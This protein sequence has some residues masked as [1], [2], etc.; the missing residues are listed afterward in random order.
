MDIQNLEL[1][2][3]EAIVSEIERE[4][5]AGGLIVITFLITC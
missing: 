3:I 1:S 2:E 5:E 4:K